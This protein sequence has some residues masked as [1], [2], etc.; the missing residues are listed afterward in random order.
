MP[1][2]QIAPDAGVL[3]IGI[4][5]LLEV[6]DGLAIK[7]FRLLELAGIFQKLGDLHMTLGH[8]ATIPRLIIGNLFFQRLLNQH[9]LPVRRRLLAA[10]VLSG[11]LAGLAGALYTA[12]YGTVSSSVGLGIE[13]QA[14]AAAVIG[15]VAIF[16]GSGSVLG[17]A[18]GALLLN[19]IYSALIVVNVSSFWASAFAGGLLLAAIAFDRLIALRVAPALRTRRRAR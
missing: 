12:R 4:G 16:G 6:F 5:Q 18:L 17:A 9:G 1:P 7:L 8:V 15:G 11:A 19:V 2:S 14:V 10:F 3:R 13:L